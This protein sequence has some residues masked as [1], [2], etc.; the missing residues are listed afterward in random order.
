MGKF[1]EEEDITGGAVVWVIGLVVFA[2]GFL[3]GWLVW[4]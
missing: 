2:C 4:G 3:G 1:Y